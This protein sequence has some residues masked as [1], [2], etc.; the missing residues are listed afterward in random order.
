MIYQKELQP[1]IIGDIDYYNNSFIIYSH[2]CP[3]EEDVLFLDDGNEYIVTE[4][5]DD[6]DDD[7]REEGLEYTK[8]KFKKLYL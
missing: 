1:Y 8:V 5:I 3:Y 4:L 6:T 2:E 7:E